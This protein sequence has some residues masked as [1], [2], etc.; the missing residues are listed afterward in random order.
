MSEAARREFGEGP[1][2]RIAAFVYTLLVVEVL[3]IVAT[4]PS[5][6]LLMLLDRDASNIPLAAVLAI[7]L[8]PAASAALYGVYR[9][10]S[11]LTD[12]RPAAAFWRGYRANLWGVL[13][14]WVPWLAWLAVVA[15]ILTNFAA[16]GIPL[17]WAV[18]LGIVA[19]VSTL[20]YANALVISSLFT[21]R[22]RDVARLAVY[23][24]GHR[25]G[26]TI[27]HACLLIVATGV[28]LVWSEAAVVPLAAI[29]AL[30]LLAT[31]RPMIA[32]IQERFAA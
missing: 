16:A 19:L 2:A 3:F 25:P 29:F 5:F 11:D 22:A 15:I 28:T 10:H 21:F 8:G 18:L 7:P 30:G 17:W 20:W 26:A 1:L 23:F 24:L 9:R 12:L 27:G 14:L 6:I 13:R 31:S 4:A 32:E